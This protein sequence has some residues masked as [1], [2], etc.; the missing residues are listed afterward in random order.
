MA[1][2][3]NGIAVIVLV[4]SLARWTWQLVA[5]IVPKGIQGAPVTAPAPPTRFTASRIEGA[6]LFGAPPLA[7]GNLNAIPVSSLN[8]LLTGIV[9]A[10]ARSFA[11]I[12]ANGRHQAPFLVGQQVAPGASLIAIYADRVLIRHDGR[13]ESVLLKQPAPANVQGLAP[14][15]ATGLPPLVH[16]ITPSHYLVPPALVKQEVANPGPLLHQ[17]LMVPYEAG[18]FLIR[19]IVPGSLYQQ[20]GLKPGDVIRSVNG[21]PIDSLAQAMQIYQ[22]LPASGEID[23][24]ILRNGQPKELHYRI[25]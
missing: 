1:P 24:Q 15:T 12:K 13:V 21:Q 25:Q 22:R 23:L 14:A 4:V 8:L 11:L 19:S 7:A 10:G 18:G 2:A 9:E 16:R 5:P 17:A 3:V 6:D 20:L